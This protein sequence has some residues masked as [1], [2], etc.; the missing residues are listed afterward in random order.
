MWVCA[1]SD[2]A[3]CLS[4]TAF[5]SYVLD[6]RKRSPNNFLCCPHH[7]LKAPPAC[8]CTAAAPHRDAVI[9]VALPEVHNNIF[10]FVHKNIEVLLIKDSVFLFRIC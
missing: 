9:E 10:C 7:S 8:S 1:V 3:P 5:V 6:G 4:Q 2:K